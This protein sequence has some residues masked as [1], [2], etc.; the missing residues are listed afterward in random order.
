MDGTGRVT[1]IPVMT[2][3]A[4]PVIATEDT[5]M[6]SSSVGAQGMAFGLS[7]GTTWRDENCQRLK[8]SRELNAMGFNRA[9]VALLCVD[10]DVRDAMNTAGTPCPGAT[11]SAEAQPQRR[12][13]L[14]GRQERRVRP[15]TFSAFAALAVGAGATAPQA[16]AEESAEGG[17]GRKD[18]SLRTNAPRSHAWLRSSGS[19]AYDPSARQPAPEPAPPTANENNSDGALLTT[20]D[21]SGAPQSSSGSEAQRAIRV[22]VATAF[23]ASL[24][25]SQET[26]MGLRSF[27]VQAIGFGLSVA[28]TWPDRQCRRIRNARALEEF[29]YQSAAIALLCQDEDVFDAMQRA[30][31]P[32]PGAQLLNFPL[33]APE[34][35]PAEPP[36]MRFQ[37]VL[38]DFDRF[39]LRPEADAILLPVLEML[40]RNPA[41]NVDIE[42]HADWMGSDAYNIGLSQRRA[43]SVVEWL[44]AH[45]IARER[46]VA[47]GKGEREPIASNETAEGRQLNRRVEVRRR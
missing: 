24:T 8:N 13:G 38:F 29:G 9:A 32:C 34:H 5:C 19:E 16:L 25:A 1:E 3:Y 23:A 26:C 20:D 27:G 31:T 39:N 36:L 46:L 15:A 28:T 17:A 7:V 14:F 33:P 45:G 30:G 43:Q 22:P 18:P 6:G 21:L 2:A 42:G 40:Q 37:D 47:V 10:G 44:V 12:R 11:Q 4:A 35:E 41:L